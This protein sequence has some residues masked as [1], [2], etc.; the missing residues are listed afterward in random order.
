MAL[1]ISRYIYLQNY[2]NE[3]LSVN[4]YKYKNILKTCYNI[5]LLLQYGMAAE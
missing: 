1:D 3:Y 2:L 4:T 5:S